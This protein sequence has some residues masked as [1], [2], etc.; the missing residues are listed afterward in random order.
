ML[1]L[2][3]DEPSPPQVHSSSHI[4]ASRSPH[5][6]TS[7]GDL[8]PKHLPL[9]PNSPSNEQAKCE[10]P[11]GE[12]NNNN[13]TSSNH[14]HNPNHIRTHRRQH[15]YQLYPNDT[16]AQLEGKAPK[17]NTKMQTKVDAVGQI[18]GPWGKWQLRTVLLI[19]LCKIPSSWFMACIIFT[20][21]APRHGEFFCKPPHNRSPEPNAMDQ[22]L[23]S[24]EG[25][26]RRSG[27]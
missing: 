2:K 17:P 23:A 16:F 8:E 20:A 9:A 3:E 13:S 11:E 5:F 18:T 24:A 4:S 26:E 21:P 10:G 6:G 25:G 22:G 14:N 12:A 7:A 15:E 27:V 1:P 19:F